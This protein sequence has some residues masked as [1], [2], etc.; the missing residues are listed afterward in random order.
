MIKLGITIL[1]YLFINR[2]MVHDIRQIKQMS[3]DR[4]S[5]DDD[6]KSCAKLDNF[7]LNLV[8]RKSNST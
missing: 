8:G 3:T 6:A 4:E 1:N 7:W 2:Q 5:V